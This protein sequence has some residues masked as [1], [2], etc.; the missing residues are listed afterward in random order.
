MAG[1]PGTVGGAVRGNAGAFGTEMKD[2]LI[3]ARAFNTETGDIR[4]FTNAECAFAYRDSFFKRNPAWVV[5]GA[6]VALAPVDAAESATRI[7]D[8]ISEREKRHLQDVRAAGS[9]FTNPVAPPEVVKQFEAEK[10]VRSR[11][12][13]VPAGWLIEKAGMKGVALGGAMAS[14]QHPNYL[15]NATGD[16]TAADVR[17]LAEK[18]K[19]AVRDRFGI[20]L[21]EEAAQL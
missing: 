12:S 17:A 1:I 3:E 10:G 4:I 19:D 16:A 5:L 21:I 15:V 18:V 6:T 8:T 11:E 9:Y 2:V 13:R 14:L 7:E 20:E